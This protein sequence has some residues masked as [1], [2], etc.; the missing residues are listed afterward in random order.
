MNLPVS[1]ADVDRRLHRLIGACVL[2]LD[3]RPELLQN[4]TRQIAK[5]SNPR[6]RAEW[7]ELLRLP[8]PA[9]RRLL[10]EESADGDRRRQSAPFGGLL[11]NE[12][13]FRILRS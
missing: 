3:A 7:T 8:W 13:R 11:T 9:L 5:W 12:E 4:A 10:L 1:H 6:L 2:K